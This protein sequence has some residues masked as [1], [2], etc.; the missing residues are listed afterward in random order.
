M[1]Y[2][3]HGSTFS[4]KLN[5]SF[6]PSHKGVEVLSYVYKTEGMNITRG[7]GKGAATVR[8]SQRLRL[9]LAAGLACD[10]DFAGAFFFGWS[11]SSE[12]SP[13][14][15]PPSVRFLSAAELGQ[16]VR[17]CKILENEVC[18]TLRSF[19]LELVPVFALKRM[20]IISGLCHSRSWN[21]LPSLSSKSDSLPSSSLALKSSWSLTAASELVSLDA[22][23]DSAS[24]SDSVSVSSSCSLYTRLSKGK[25]Q[26]KS[27]GALP[28]RQ[29]HPRT[30]N[31]H[32]GKSRKD[33]R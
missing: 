30:S 17:T 4:N 1:F 13:F 33:C 5:E 3:A 31:L 23:R 2:L 25:G 7:R 12:S 11:E 9:P 28:H 8:R 19:L 15:R 10:L 29:C 22:C 27:K 6:R 20:V 26:I 24:N 14:P 16:L 18:L 21:T 32:L